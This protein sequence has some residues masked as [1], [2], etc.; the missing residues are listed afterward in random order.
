M[1]SKQFHILIVDDRDGDRRVILEALREHPAFAGDRFSEAA[2]LAALRTLLADRDF[3]P[4][5]VIMDIDLDQDSEP[6]DV[7]TDALDEFA[8]RADLQPAIILTTGSERLDDRSIDQLISWRDSGEV[9][10]LQLKTP[11][12]VLYRYFIAQSARGVRAEWAAHQDI[13]DWLRGVGIVT[14]SPKM[15]DL[16]K[17]VERV[18]KGTSNILL[19]GESGTGKELVAGAVH[20]WSARSQMQL[21]TVNMATLSPE[22]IGSELFGHVRGAFTS[23]YKDQAGLFERADKGTLLLDEIAEL[24]L[25]QQPKLLRAIEEQKIARLGSEKEQ[26][27]DVRMIAATNQDLA[28]QMANGQFRPELY[29]RLAGVKFYIPSLRERREDIEPLIAHFVRDPSQKRGRTKFLAP[30]AWEAL[31]A[32]DWPGNVRELKNAVQQACDR[33]ESDEVRVRDLPDE[34][35]DWRPRRSASSTRSSGRGVIPRGSVSGDSYVDEPSTYGYPFM[36]WKDRD[37]VHERATFESLA[38][39]FHGKHP[40]AAERLTQWNAAL[41]RHQ[42]QTGKADPRPLHPY[43]VIA[44]L[45]ILG[46]LSRK[47]IEDLIGLSQGQV[48]KVVDC[49]KGFDVGLVNDQ[50]GKLVLSTESITSAE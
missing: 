42:E 3:R 20:Q 15:I 11:S 17:A 12:E 9:K 8:R 22:L 13:D 19:L 7:V 34:I 4:S 43:K 23:A 25:A 26:K 18:A 29:Y 2:S 27:I 30:E 16:L 35:R 44:L 5:L 32:Y 37:E 48:Q 10:D 31:A 21:V 1:A 49:L 47:A 45:L 28:A 6:L 36:T 41:R 33:A 46:P 24:P 50:K 14:R 39:N 38:K 40:D